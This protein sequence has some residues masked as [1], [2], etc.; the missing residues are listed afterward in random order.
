MSA[1]LTLRC[2]NSLRRQHPPTYVAM[3]YMAESMISFEET[4][5]ARSAILRR[6]ITQPAKDYHRAP[7]FKSLG[8]FGVAS[9]RELFMPSPFASLAEAVVLS[10]IGKSPEFRKH[11]NVYSYLWPQKGSKGHNFEHYYDGYQRRNSSIVEALC[12]KP[13]M[14]ALVVDIKSFYPSVRKDDARKEMSE[15][16]QASDLA[17]DIK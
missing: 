15:K 3:R 10:E 16:L 2:L 11:P 14:V 9:Y 17:L 6:Y 13:E 7:R 1:D 5:F 4:A 8:E 12:L